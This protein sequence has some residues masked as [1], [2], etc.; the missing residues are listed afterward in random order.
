MYF[1]HCLIFGF[2]NI[3]VCWEEHRRCCNLCHGCGYKI[4]NN[5]RDSFYKPKMFI[6]L[7]QSYI[8]NLQ[9]KQ[10]CVLFHYLAKIHIFSE[11]NYKTPRQ[12]DNTIPSGR[13]SQTDSS[14]LAC[15]CCDY[16]LHQARF[17]EETN[18]KQTLWGY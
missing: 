14:I 9:S 2:T 3:R 15:L 5:Y 17:C 1:Y 16:G 18:H 13:W 8:T 10:W 7:Y 11:T 12:T 6:E 4:L